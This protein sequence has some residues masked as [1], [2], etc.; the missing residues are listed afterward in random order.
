MDEQQKRKLYEDFQ[1][2]GVTYALQQ[3]YCEFK[4]RVGA[5]PTAA[6]MAATHRELKQMIDDAY[7]RVIGGTD[8]QV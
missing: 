2:R 3:W 1:K 5:P 8:G 6:E 4:E 7:S